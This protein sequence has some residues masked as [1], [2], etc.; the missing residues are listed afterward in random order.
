[1]ANEITLKQIRYFAE[2]AE[3]GH[4]RK[5]AERVG[6]SQPSLSLQVS[7]LEATLG[8]RLV[9]RGRAGAV[10]TLEGREVLT[11][12]QEILTN[13]DLLSDTSGRMKTGLAGTMRLGSS[14]TLGPYLLPY[15]AMHLRKNFPDLRLII[16]DGAPYDLVGDI[17]AGRHDL[18]LTQL[19]L[20]SSDLQFV[21]LFR[22][23]L[24]LAV[25]LDHPLADK[26]MVSDKDLSGEN[27]LTLSTRFTLHSQIAQLAGEVG[28][29]LRQDYE[30][31]SLDAIRQMTAMNMG[32][33]FLPALYANLE[34]P[35]VGGDVSLLPY[36]SGRFSRSIGL[37]WRKSSS[38]QKAF[39]IFSDV[40]RAVARD[41]FTGVISLDI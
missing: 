19:P 30:G 6:I 28:A 36:R 25:S 22:E 32:V 5:A 13:V 1:M 33:T 27:I 37:A 8:L 38:N 2:L 17:L 24:V 9:E 40:I 31:T 15:V 12:A 4:Y 21:R 29:N 3:A 18:L 14:P 34:V 41:R 39:E 35:K 10:L 11:L 16:R 26:E 7:N 23:P 20:P